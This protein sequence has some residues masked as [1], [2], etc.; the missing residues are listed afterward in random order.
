MVISF[1]LQHPYPTD[2][3]KRTIAAQTNLNVLQVDSW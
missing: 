3:E 1:V 2:E